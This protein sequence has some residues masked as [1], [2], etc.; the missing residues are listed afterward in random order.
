MSLIG[1][2]EDASP[3]GLERW[4]GVVSYFVGNDPKNWRSGIPTYAKVDNARIY[5]E[6]G[7]DLL[8]ESAPVGV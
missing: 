4:S 8:R 1:A 6:R 2:N 3:A 7:F 5:S